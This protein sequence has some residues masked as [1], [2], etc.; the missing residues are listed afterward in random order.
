MIWG[1]G[2]GLSIEYGSNVLGAARQ[3][4][5]CAPVAGL[6]INSKTGEI[7]G[8]PSMTPAAAAGQCEARRCTITAFN[9]SGQV[10]AA[11]TWDGL[12]KAMW[13][14]QKLVLTSFAFCVGVATFG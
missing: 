10:V 6:S 1:L 13:W 2:P 7:V 14:A 4:V 3:L 12:L 5:T 11:V 9:D 8:T